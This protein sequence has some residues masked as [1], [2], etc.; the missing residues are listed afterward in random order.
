MGSD[1]QPLGKSNMI[2]KKISFVHKSNIGKVSPMPPVE[3]MS[4]K[5]RGLFF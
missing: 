2:P 1:D 3:K 4:L 5:E